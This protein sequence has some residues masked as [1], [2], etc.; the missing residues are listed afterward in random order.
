ME[1]LVLLALVALL[2]VLPFYVIYKPPGFVIGY[3]ARR[4]PDVLWRVVLPRQPTGRGRGEVKKV[5]AL[6]IDDAPSRYTDDI[7]ALLAENGAHATFF[8]IGGQVGDP[9]GPGEESLKRLVRAGH[10]LGNH[11]MHDEPARSLSDAELERQIR[12]VERRIAKVYDDVSGEAD[13]DDGETPPRRPP[14]YFRPGSGFFSDRMRALLARIGYRLVLGSIYPHDAQIPY[15]WINARH[16]LSMLRPGAIIICHD[17]RSWT[18]PMLRRVLPEIRRRG[19]EIV[20]VTRLLE[21]AK[22]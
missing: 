17:R 1:T 6:T 21:E 18:L 10:E 14:R 7:A 3:L 2:L 13:E 12:E 5:V 9:S 22:G 20:T 19:Y 16:V 4:W 8:V 11:A 15:A